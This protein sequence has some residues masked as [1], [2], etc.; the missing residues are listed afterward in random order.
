[1][2][3]LDVWAAITAGVGAAVV[4]P[5]TE[6]PLSKTAL[7]I[8][9][10]KLTLSSGRNNVWCNREWPEG[11]NTKAPKCNATAPC[12]FDVSVMHPSTQCGYCFDC[13]SYRRRLK[14]L[15]ML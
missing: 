2:D 1:M 15:T 3:S 12:L 8:G 4:V 5:R 7:V 9:D 11:K 10:H 13:C 14:R 6:V